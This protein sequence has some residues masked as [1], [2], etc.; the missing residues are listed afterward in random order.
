MYS[1]NR[2]YQHRNI[3][4]VQLQQKLP[5]QKYIRC[6]AAIEAANIEI[7]QM[8]SC[9]RSCQHRHISDVQLQQKLPT[10]KYIRCTAANICLKVFFQIK[11]ET[12]YFIFSCI[13]IYDKGEIPGRQPKNNNS[14]SGQH[15]YDNVISLEST[16]HD[17]PHDDDG[18]TAIEGP[19]NIFGKR[20]ST[21]QRTKVT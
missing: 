4:D 19:E 9:N 6:T 21:L 13:Q 20:V 5:T 3:S 18:N 15:Q 11:T 17:S 1:C 7:Y 10:Q 16:D 8:Y 12:I 14:V 2:S